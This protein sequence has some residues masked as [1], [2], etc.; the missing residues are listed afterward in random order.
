MVRL[1][2]KK[3]F[4]DFRQKMQN[5]FLKNCEKVQ[6]FKEDETFVTSEL[7]GSSSET[8]TNIGPHSAK[9]LDSGEIRLEQT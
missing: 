8:R 7:F 9:R 1:Y 2:I 5:P 6:K 4:L 3:H